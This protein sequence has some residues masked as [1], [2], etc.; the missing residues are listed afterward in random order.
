MPHVWAGEFTLVQ[1]TNGNYAMTVCCTHRLELTVMPMQVLDLRLGPNDSQ[2]QKLWQMLAHREFITCWTVGASWENWTITSYYSKKKNSD[3]LLAL[4]GFRSLHVWQNMFSHNLIVHNFCSTRL[5]VVQPNNKEGLVVVVHRNPASKAGN[6]AFQNGD[7]RKHD[8]VSKPL[9]GTFR[10]SPLRRLHRLERHV[11]RINESKEVRDQLEASNQ[12]DGKEK[13][14]NA[15]EEKVNLGITCL[16]F[17]LLELLC[18]N[19]QTNKTLDMRHHSQLW[20]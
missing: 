16:F 7:K 17:K 12:P 5:G 19:M 4:F 10:N 3:D 2:C 11:R 1:L 9:S 20:S 13:N 6:Y 18:A 15:S 8:P 14:H